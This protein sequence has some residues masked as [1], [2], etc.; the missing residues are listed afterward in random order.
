MRRISIIC[1]T[2]FLLAL[3]N[4]L[5]LYAKSYKIIKI[6]IIAT[7][8]LDGS[9][10]IQEFR[11]YKF[12]GRFRWADYRKSVKGFDSIENFVL[13]DENFIYH[14]S[15]GKEKG[16]Y[17]VSYSND[18]FY[19]KWFYSARNESKTFILSYKL[20]NILNIYPDVAELNYQFVGGEWDHGTREVNVIVKLPY[21]AA[22]DEVRAWAHGP[23]WGNV[24][25]MDET[26]IHLDIVDLP[27]YR[28]WEGRIL[29]PARLVSNLPLSAS[30]S[31][32]DN[33]IA[34]ESQWAREANEARIRAQQELA[35]R[36]KR[37]K[38]GAIVLSVLAIAGFLIWLPIFNQ[39]GRPYPSKFRSQ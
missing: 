36:N 17:Q 28:F 7:V 29:F 11:T 31:M 22:L 27:R 25:I 4:V 2:I 20:T 3:L 13:R 18:E 21:G 39:H 15:S 33:I 19:V 6:E 32:L 10:D 26:T 9:I 23:L 5:S 34:E 24:T 35:E 16:T 1:M 14:S 30:T 37:W 38:T 8:N 12:K